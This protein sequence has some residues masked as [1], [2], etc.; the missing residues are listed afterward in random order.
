M[1]QLVELN[2]AYDEIRARGAEIL[3]I[4]L[5]CS[6]EGTAATAERENIRYPMANDHELT[7]ATAFSPTS[8]YLIDLDGTIA[9]RWLDRIHDRATAA[10]I[11][12]ALDELAAPAPAP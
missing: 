5:E 2:E 12:T 7:M 8:T 9:A 1:R 10:A 6:P 4:H 11:L 3:A